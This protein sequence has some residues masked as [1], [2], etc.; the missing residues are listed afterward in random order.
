MQANAVSQ[1][2]AWVLVPRPL[3]YR[4]SDAVSMGGRRRKSS[5][6][7]SGADR[8]HE[9]SETQSSSFTLR[10]RAWML[11]IVVSQRAAWLLVQTRDNHGDTAE[12][13]GCVP[14]TAAASG[15]LLRR[16]THGRM[17]GTDAAAA[18]TRA[19]KPSIPRADGARLPQDIKRR[20]RP[21][22]LTRHPRQRG[23]MVL[24]AN[25]PAATAAHAAAR[26]I[27][28][29][30]AALP[31]DRAFLPRVCGLID[32]SIEALRCTIARC[33]CTDL[34]D[35]GNANDLNT[36][37]RAVMGDDESSTPR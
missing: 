33:S 14:Q 19:T 17:Q 29:L 4:V 1:R 25:A 12:S 27:A 21:R 31:L 34:S 20:H 24:G 3:N 36:A 30:A 10:H 11:A 8:V 22:E 13:A 26:R 23:T 15:I 35:R 9:A 7:V 18:C 5:A 6:S 37:L 16:I 28:P 2:A 32:Y